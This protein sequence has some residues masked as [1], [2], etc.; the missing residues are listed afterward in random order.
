M[1][2]TIDQALMEELAPKVAEQILS[3]H[4][5]SEP[6]INNSKSNQTSKTQN[7]SSK[8]SSQSQKGVSFE[9]D[10]SIEELIRIVREST[11]DEIEQNIKN[12]RNKLDEFLN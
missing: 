12:L 11:D 7:S 10:S 2:E 1:S 8:T 3:Q 6:S 4:S 9:N 5:T